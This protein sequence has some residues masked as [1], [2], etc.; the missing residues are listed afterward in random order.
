MIARCHN[1]NDK[2]Y[3]RYGARGIYVCDAWR[4]SFINFYQDMGARPEGMTLD[5]IN[6]DGPYSK[7]NCRWVSHKEN[8]NNRFRKEKMIEMGTRFGKLTVVRYEKELPLLQY[9]VV[10]ICGDE[11]IVR[12]CLLKKGK[13]SQCKLCGYKKATL[14]RARVQ[15]TKEEKKPKCACGVILKRTAL[16]CR[17][18]YMK[19]IDTH[20]DRDKS[21][22][23]VRK[24]DGQLSLSEFKEA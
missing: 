16:E 12:G 3:L 18:C 8:C 10:C 11:F 6:N 23:F 17:G 5:R 24:L 4:D 9:K 1:V 21:G 13:V 19:R 15:A 2:N 20:H 7:E 14:S 22:K